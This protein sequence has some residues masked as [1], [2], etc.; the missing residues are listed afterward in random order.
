MNTT[1][2][3]ADTTANRR[4]GLRV[5]GVRVPGVRVPGVAALAVASG[6]VLAACS[7][8]EEPAATPSAVS[9]SATSSSSTSATSTPPAP[10]D[11]P[12]PAVTAPAAV[13]ATH[14]PAPSANQLPALVVDT[15]GPCHTIG[16][17]AQAMDGSP[18]F[19]LNDPMAG[20][21][22]LPQPEAGPDATGPVLRDQPCAQENL[23][24]TAPDGTT[25]TC[26][27]TGDGTT[28]GGLFW[29]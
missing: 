27:L 11:D 16:E 8:G 14:A 7:G 17:V 1:P 13:S 24:V 29:Q 6:L 3:P 23:A 4:R 18:L 2:H 20:P 25:L 12:A 5:P 28:P 22:W 10:I 19:C 15:G 21:L 26:S 9:S